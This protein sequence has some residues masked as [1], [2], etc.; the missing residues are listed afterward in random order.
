LSDYG[1]F[2]N[3]DG[4]L[5]DDAEEQLRES[6]D[7]YGNSERRMLQSA[8]AWEGGKN[9]CIMETTVEEGTT[10]R[11]YCWTTCNDAEAA[12]EDDPT[13]CAPQYMYWPPSFCKKGDEGCEGPY[14][15]RKIWT[16]NP[17]FDDK[18]DAIGD[19]VKATQSYAEYDIGYNW[20]KAKKFENFSL[21][22]GSNGYIEEYWDELRCYSFILLPGT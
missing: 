18:E 21:H 5:I 20:S 8:N 15:T 22:T 6:H 3:A 10:Q 4:D 7:H 12:D 19:N 13:K 14:M 1:I 11:W 2:V 16:M 9:K 17:D